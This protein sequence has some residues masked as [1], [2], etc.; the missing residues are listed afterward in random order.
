MSKENTRKVV[1]SSV[2]LSRFLSN[3]FGIHA[4]NK[5]VPSFMYSASIECKKA[6][7]M[8]CTDGDG[9][10]RK[11]GTYRLVSSSRK[12]LLGVQ[13]LMASM[14]YWSSLIFSRK[15]GIIA[16][17]CGRDCM[18]RGLWELDFIFD[19]HKKA[20]YREDDNNFYVPIKKI[21]K[22]YYKGNVIN[23]TVKG[24]GDSNH[25]YIIHNLL[26]ANCDG[27]I[28]HERPDFKQ[29]DM[30]RDQNLGNV[31]WR[32]LRFNEESIDENMDAVTD[33]ISKHIEEASKQKKAADAD[34]QLVKYASTL[35]VWENPQY[36]QCLA[37]GEIGCHRGEI[38]HG[39]IL[40]IGNVTNG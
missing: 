19:K 35:K 2:V 16:K 37:S 25:T 7:I 10:Q 4:P 6:F 13:S 21:E 38:P 39:K 1:C 29:R 27:A 32:I 17:I 31:G 15:P 3:N 40:Y 26:N 36:E 20:I 9:C 12:L 22:N 24:E 5:E 33:V 28:W 30:N 8:G 14:G 23:Y 18:T 34:E 11:D